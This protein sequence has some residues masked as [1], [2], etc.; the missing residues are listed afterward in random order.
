MIETVYT[1][2]QDQLNNNE[3]FAGLVGGSVAATLLYWAKSL[4]GKIYAGI[5]WM[6]LRHLTVEVTVSN[7]D[8]VQFARIS[9]W[10]NEVAGNKWNKFNLEFVSCSKYRYSPA[11]SDADDEK[12][13][14]G[15]GYGSFGFWHER[16]YYRVS[17]SKSEQGNTGNKRKEETIS[18]R[19]FSRDRGFIDRIINASKAKKK[20]VVHKPSH[21]YSGSWHE[22]STLVV[23]EWNTVF[24]PEKQKDRIRNDIEWFV[25]HEHI[26]IEAGIPACRGYLF[27]GPPGT[28]KTTMARAIASLLEVDLYLLPLGDCE[29]DKQLLEL[30][31]EVADGSILVFEDIDILDVVVSR[32]NGGKKKGKKG[33]ISLGGLLQALDGVSAAANRMVIM[34][35]NCPEKL[36][37]ALVRKGRIDLQEEILPLTKD[38]AIGMANALFDETYEACL[39]QL[40]Y[41]ATGAEVQGVLLEE[42]Q[43]R[44]FREEERQK[45]LQEESEET[46]QDA[47]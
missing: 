27:H 14:L 16:K 23:R 29:N 6:Y 24:L 40:E 36:D 31:Q 38:L 37:P 30:V 2:F 28:G 44:W 9:R 26:Y 45:V 21:G 35:T 5:K 17:R 15:I 11:V 47:T 32:E 46:T 41:P 34:T 7:V 39:D 18:V 19:R 8:Y 10:L 3:M 33:G 22:S 42:N 25:R 20:P 43:K 13:S 4:P 12:A 1:W